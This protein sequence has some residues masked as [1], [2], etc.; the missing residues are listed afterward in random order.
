M[1]GPGGAVAGNRIATLHSEEPN[2]YYPRFSQLPC[3]NCHTNANANPP[4]AWYG[5]GSQLQAA[6]GAV[7]GADGIFDDE[8]TIRLAIELLQDGVMPKLISNTLAPAGRDQSATLSIDPG[9]KLDLT[10]DDITDFDFIGDSGIGAALDG[11]SVDFSFDEIE[12]DFR[13]R[14]ERRRR[15]IPF[16]VHLFIGNNLFRATT[17]DNLATNTVSI[18][19]DNIAPVA[20]DDAFE[21]TGDPA[22]VL[23]ENVFTQGADSDPDSGNLT[24]QLVDGLEAG[25]GTLA[26]EPDGDFDYT[27]PD[28]P[29]T[30]EREVSFT[31]SVTDGEGATSNLATARINVLG[32]VPANVPAEAVNDVFTIDEDQRLDGNV[33]TDAGGGADI[34]PDGGPEPLSV[35]V[36]TQP[37]FGRLRLRPTAASATCRSA[38]RPATPTARTAS[39][40][41][42]ATAALSTARR[43]PS[44]SSRRTTRRSP[45]AYGAAA[46]TRRPASRPTTC[47][48]RTCERRRRRPPE[49]G[50]RVDDARGQ[51]AR[52]L[53]RELHVRVPARAGLQ[54]NA[55]RLDALDEGEDG[56]AGL[57]L[58][59]SRP[60]AG[61][62]DEGELRVRSTGIDDGHRP[63]DRASTPPPWPTATTSTSSRA[64]SSP[65]LPFL[66]RG[67][68][69]S[70]SDFAVEDVSGRRADR[71]R[72]RAL[73]AARPGQGAAVGPAQA[74]EAG[75]AALRAAARQDRAPSWSA[76]P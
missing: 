39:S 62:T 55:K 46:S 47:S 53:R 4:C 52:P 43:S 28:P 26:F 69:G 1:L 5:Y 48:T 63:G 72:P 21:T 14:G 3:T 75:R 71:L 76:P 33:V 35:A 44:A 41:A 11:N 19:F 32:F 20:A 8:T 57:P 12:L 13:E 37:S 66:P 10:A 7:C 49:G 24:A 45:A 42:S 16:E 40:T 51:C 18:T 54:F 15:G 30:D 60:T 61:A 23:E 50:A 38:T 34:D 68:P 36:V 27:P 2:P 31:Y 56:H 70:A 74:A 22:V 17:E 67:R 29:S 73:P 59:G 9:K 58:R 6:I 64:A 65:R 25:E